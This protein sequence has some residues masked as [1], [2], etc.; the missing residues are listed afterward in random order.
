MPL[1]T[2]S[3]LRGSLDGLTKTHTHSL[4]SVQAL[5]VEFGNEVKDHE[6]CLLFIVSLFSCFDRQVRLRNEITKKEVLR[7]LLI[8]MDGLT[9]THTHSL[10]SE[11]G[12]L[13]VRWLVKIIVHEL[14]MM[15]LLISGG[16]PFSNLRA[17]TEKQ[18]G[19]HVGVK[20]S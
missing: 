13:V 16:V 8:S 19:C 3:S 2:Y 15:Y 4:A 12:S 7:Q 5:L 17:H 1:I 9:K 10:A 14:I 6:F 11:P 20:Y 18:N